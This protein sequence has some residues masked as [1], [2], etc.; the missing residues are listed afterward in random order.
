MVQKLGPGAPLA[1]V[2]NHVAVRCWQ[3]PIYMGGFLML[4]T[5]SKIPIYMLNSCIAGMLGTRNLL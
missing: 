1:V 3:K 5:I 4:T 2:A